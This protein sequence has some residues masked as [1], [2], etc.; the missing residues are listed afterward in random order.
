VI[1]AIHADEGGISAPAP[2]GR[3]RRSPQEPG[4]S[5]EPARELNA[6][7]LE[8]AW[9][10]EGGLS[11]TTDTEPRP[12]PRQRAQML[13]CCAGDAY[14]AG[15]YGQALRLLGLARAADPSQAPRLDKH[16]ARASAARL[17]AEP[18]GRPLAEVV[19][20]RIADAG[21]TSDD[22]A[23]ARIAEHNTRALGC[24]AAGSAP[25]SEPERGQFRQQVLAAA[26]ELEAGS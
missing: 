18:A 17:A 22:P 7:A 2:A 1:V 21:I 19:A 11:M 20:A 10:A 4:R 25:V 23:L 16:R 5:P 3:V 9:R 12:D 13:H 8:H 26:A 6:G 15:H 24:G 14:Q